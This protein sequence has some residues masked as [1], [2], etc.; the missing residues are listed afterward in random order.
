MQNPSNYS[1]SP[2]T[3]AQ[4]MAG[5]AAAAPEGSFQSL[6]ALPEDKLTLQ[7]DEQKTALANLAEA[8]WQALILS[9]DILAGLAPVLDELSAT[10]I[11]QADLDVSKTHAAV[12][13]KPVPPVDILKV[14]AAKAR[15]KLLALQSK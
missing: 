7:T 10:L 13:G 2:L 3:L 4:A 14:Q 15:L 12:P 1:F 11:I 9:K 8:G 6:M 5:L